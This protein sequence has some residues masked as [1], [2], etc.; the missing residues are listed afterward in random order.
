MST[1]F[2]CSAHIFL[3]TTVIIIMTT[4]PCSNGPCNG[5]SRRTF[6]LFAL[7]FTL[8]LMIFVNTVWN[9]PLKNSKDIVDSWQE[10][11]R[12]Q[13]LV[14]PSLSLLTDGISL[15][16][17]ARDGNVTET[18]SSSSVSGAYSL[19]MNHAYA[20][21]VAGCDPNKP[22]YL[23]YIYNVLVAK[24]L[25]RQAGST[26]DVIVMIRMA[27][28]TNE[29][30]LPKEQQALLTTVGII[31]RY[32][33]KAQ[34]DNFYT[35][36]MDKFRILELTA[37]SRVL[38]LDSDVMP[39]C[40]LDYVLDNTDG[41]NAPMRSSVILKTDKSPSNGGFFVLSPSLDDYKAV[42]D[43]IAKRETYGYHYN[44]TVGWGRIFEPPD[45]W[46]A[47]GDE[48]ACSKSKN[49]DWNFYGSMADQG[50]LYYFTKYFK[51]DVTEI[52]AK[53]VGD[54]TGPLHNG[55]APDMALSDLQMVLH[56]DRN[57]AVPGCLTPPPFRH[58]RNQRNPPYRDFWHFAG[59]NKPWRSQP[60]VNSTENS[61]RT[62]WWQTLRA[63]NL[64]Y[65]LNLPNEEDLG[66]ILQ[67]KPPLGFY[68]THKQV[69]KK[70]EAED[71]E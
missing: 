57:R 13:T 66:N 4:L 70:V 53:G 33:P 14:I 48:L 54:W 56:D 51:K 55:E 2:C 71:S 10:L 34:T 65:N 21:L 20:F 17:A 61:P 58:K 9:M 40:N 69:M 26:K 22:T 32:I 45:C 41:P 59:R 46:T 27:T 16:A 19:N 8:F 38:F 39:L 6:G 25:L 30:V 3:L 63:T 37:Y 49:T 31:V 42:Q 44:N 1:F 7:L 23:G 35:A 12:R 50:L 62:L 11:A 67:G 29:T 36:M 15:H 64:T 52:G 5:G 43:I 28:S 60:K 68:P 24:E 47:I 18:S